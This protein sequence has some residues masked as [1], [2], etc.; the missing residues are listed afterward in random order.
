MTQTESAE[1]A[2]WNGARWRPDDPRGHYESWFCPANHPT[3]PLAFWIRYTIFSP[4]GRPEDADGV[5]A[6]ADW[7]GVDRALPDGALA[8]GDGSLADGVLADR[9]LADRA[10]GHI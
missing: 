9:A 2:A 5:D 3:E 6:G 4:R 10:L 1:R 7:A 8:D